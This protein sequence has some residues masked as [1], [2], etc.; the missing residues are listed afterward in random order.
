MEAAFRYRPLPGAS[1]CA[2]AGDSGLQVEPRGPSPP[3][4]TCGS[5]CFAGAAGCVATLLHDAA[6]NPAEGNDGPGPPGRGGSGAARA[7]QVPSAAQRVLT[8]LLA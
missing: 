6:M 5:S 7:T 1:A 3:P 2:S 4:L 8:S